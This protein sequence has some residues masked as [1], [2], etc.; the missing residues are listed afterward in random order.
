MEELE[1]RKEV[2]LVAVSLYTATLIIC[3]SIAF[4]V[5]QGRM[6]AF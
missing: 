4:A 3:L 6:A 5:L 1:K 2:A